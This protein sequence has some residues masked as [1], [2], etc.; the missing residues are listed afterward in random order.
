MAESPEAVVRVTAQSLNRLMSLAGESLVQAR[1]LQPFSTALLKLKKQQDHLVGLLDSVA[2][3]VSARPAASAHGQSSRREDDRRHEH[4]ERL[5]D[6]TRKQ[7]VMCR[8][9]LVERMSEFDDHGGQAEDLNSRLYREVIVSRMRP[10]ADAAHG[11]PRLVRDMARRLEKQ[12]RLEID[13]LTTE[14]D[15]DIL[16]KLEAPLTHLLR[17]AVDHGVEP[18]EE[19]LARGK[20][21][22]GL[23]RLEVRHR[24]GMLAITVSDDGGGIDLKKLRARSSSAACPRPTWP[25]PCTRPSCSNS[26]SCRASRQRRR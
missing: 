5:I 16:E 9:V 15:R 26:S 4:L 1:W 7:A 23:I 10:F 11:F 2:Q 17:N 25:P 24:A 12:V 20:P 19:R 6:E 18:P 21:E 13:G 22:Q 3:A 8:Q 14:V